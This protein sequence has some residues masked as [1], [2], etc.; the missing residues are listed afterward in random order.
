MMW[1]DIGVLFRLALPQLLDPNND[2][3]LLEVRD[4]QQE[5]LFVGDG[6]VDEHFPRNSS[7]GNSGISQ[8][9]IHVM[10]D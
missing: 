3:R 1:I 2:A 10:P 7:S 8:L 5:C 9:H 6:E 4:Q